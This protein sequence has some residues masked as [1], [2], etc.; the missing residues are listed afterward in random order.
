MALEESTPALPTSFEVVK[1]LSNDALLSAYR[2]YGTDMGKFVRVGPLIVIGPATPIQPSENFPYHKE[3]ADAAFHHTELEL[4]N[5]VREAAHNADPVKNIG[6]E[7]Y[8][9][10]LDAGHY[11]CEIQNDNVLVAVSF[12]GFSSGFRESVFLHGR[13]ETG[14]LARAALSD[15]VSVQAS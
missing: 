6:G 1:E 12:F 7:K 4:R 8:A 11:L 5:R 14:Y 15:T 3:I 10:V 2:A 9:G 13:N